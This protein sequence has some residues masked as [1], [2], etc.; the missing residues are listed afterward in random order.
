M[1]TH[2]SGITLAIVTVALALPIAAADSPQQAFARSW[3]GKSV[4]LKQVLYTLV[5]NERGKL[6]NT[7]NGRRDGLVVATPSSGAYFQFDGRQG[8]EDVVEKQPQRLVDA[9]NAAYQP[10]SLDVRGYR[11][12]E[13]VVVHRFSAGTELFVTRIRVDRDTVRVALNQTALASPDEDPATSLT[14]KWPVPFNKS[15]S[16]RELVET[17][18]LQFV[19]V[20]VPSQH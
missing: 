15:F 2:R 8:K 1:N 18:M 3:E 20:K 19:D 7:R 17:L 5:Y 13:P 14:I 9:V 12:V 4:V 16:E 6:G 11:K 10:D